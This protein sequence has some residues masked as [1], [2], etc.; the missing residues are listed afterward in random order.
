MNRDLKPAYV[1]A[2]ITLTA[3]FEL[4]AFIVWLITR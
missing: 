4:A 3:M 1:V 2:G